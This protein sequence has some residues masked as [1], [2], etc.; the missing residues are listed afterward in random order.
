M[1]NLD[2]NQYTI[3]RAELG[4]YS[5][6]RAKVVEIGMGFNQSWV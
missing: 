1:N 3:L 5:T 6:D 2:M 4:R